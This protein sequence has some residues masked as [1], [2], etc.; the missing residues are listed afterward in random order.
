MSG[1]QIILRFSSS[2]NIIV[3]YMSRHQYVEDRRLQHFKQ[4]KEIFIPIQHCW[5]CNRTHLECCFVITIRE[6]FVKNVSSS[7]G[8]GLLIVTCSVLR[9]LQAI[10]YSTAV[11]AYSLAMYPFLANGRIES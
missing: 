9:K 1:R 4:L 8:I 10:I 6:V 7:A 11:T 5:N 2:P 3:I